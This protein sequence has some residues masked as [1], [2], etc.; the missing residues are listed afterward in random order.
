MD[1]NFN[2][3]TGDPNATVSLFYSNNFGA[4]W[5][6]RRIKSNR[7]VLRGQVFTL[8]H[9]ILAD[10]GMYACKATDQSGQTIQWP[11]QTGMLFVTLGELMCP[12]YYFM[13]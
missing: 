5:S 3:T 7:L 8:S 13:K 11:P 12:I 9:V 4:T 6:E 1:V 2:C 10:N